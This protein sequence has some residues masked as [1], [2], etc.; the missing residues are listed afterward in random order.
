MESN[1]KIQYN[2]EIAKNNPDVCVAL[3]ANI[4]FFIE[5]AQVLE[6]N[7]RKLLCY[8]LSV[9]EIEKSSL[10]KET[11]EEICKKYDEY[12]LNTYQ[13]RWTLGKL[14]DEVMKLTSMPKTIGDNIK[15]INDYRIMIV[16]KIFQNNIETGALSDS[17]T[18]LNYLNQKLIPMTDETKALN[19]LI[20]KM[21][22]VYREDLHLYKNQFSLN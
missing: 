15:K 6:Y 4:G 3:Y 1:F 18:V 13:D 9:E 11:V 17:A 19:D 14:K 21:I 7:L 16:H 12:Y 5:I 22:K 10:S 2:S 20:I 8:E